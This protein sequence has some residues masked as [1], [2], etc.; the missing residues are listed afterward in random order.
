M[1]IF[2]P[3]VRSLAELA[4]LDSEP[5]VHPNGF[6]QLDVDPST[7]IHVWHPDIPYRQQTYHTVHDHAFAFRSFVLC[8]QMTSFQYDAETKPD[9]RFQIWRADGFGVKES[10]LELAAPRRYDLHP[11]KVDVAWD[12]Q[13]Y[14]M[15]D[16]V[17]HQS[18]VDR[19]TCTIIYKEGQAI[20][21]RT[22][23]GG[24]RVMVPVGMEPDNDFL[25]GDVDTD[26]L[27]EIISRV[28]PK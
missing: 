8:G 22:P 24:P 27:W 25:R 19:P 6:I 3:T 1:T 23:R 7:R 10:R 17:L 12:G 14:F 4:E 21:G 2:K 26:V 11:V 20:S 15:P 18:L 13:S 28:Y 5:R 16:G 9:G